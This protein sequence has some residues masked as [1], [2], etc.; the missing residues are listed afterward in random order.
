VTISPAIRDHI[1]ATLARV[2]AEHGVRILL[3]V[4]SGSRAWG[5]GSP[6]SDYDV[7]FIYVHPAEWY[8]S[9]E[10]PR[11]V[12]ERP[13][14]EQMVDLG[15]W[16]VRKALRLLLKSNPP[17]YEWLVSPITYRDDG[18]FRPAARDLFERHATR[19]KLA[20]HYWSIASGQYRK[21]IAGDEHARLKKYFY[22]IRPLL[23]LLWVVDRAGPP[24]MSIGELLA[25]V[26]V[27]AE[28]RDAIDG[29]LDA[30]RSTP[31]LGR[32]PRIAAIDQ[33][34][35]AQLATLA[36]GMIAFG[37]AALPDEPSATRTEADTLFRALIGWPGQ[38]ASG[39]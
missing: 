12:I 26:A 23:S 37:S 8:V 5:F 15:G 18:I 16:D 30:K 19:K 4:E 22:V 36:P 20:G 38:L 35:E 13:L 2:A 32:G 24:P 10:E 11:D 7:R 28:V 21:E 1:D 29:L 27:P 3:A 17:L 6:D 33:W 31:E 34:A 14:D 25:A 9:L 39:R